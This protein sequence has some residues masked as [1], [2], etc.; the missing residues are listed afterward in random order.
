[1]KNLTMDII[2]K[3]RAKMQE[4]IDRAG[5]ADGLYKKN[6]ELSLLISKIEAVIV[7]EAYSYIMRAEAKMRKRRQT[8]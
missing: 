6:P 3:V 2:K 8:K 5:G 7:E 4:E 1:M